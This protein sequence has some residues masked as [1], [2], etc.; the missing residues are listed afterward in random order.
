MKKI[1]LMYFLIFIVVL[2]SNYTIVDKFK[3]SYGYK[4][5]SQNDNQNSP[6]YDMYA[7]VSENRE[8]M[9]VV[10]VVKSETSNKDVSTYFKNKIKQI[11]KI[12]ELNKT[13]INRNIVVYETKVN[14]QKTVYFMKDNITGRLITKNNK[15]FEEEMKSIIY[16]FS[17]IN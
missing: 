10:D 6:N 11:S 8:N 3:N 9:L 17:P 12:S 15:N 5:T 4:I 1:I 13:I 14:N 16:T 2:S 7:T